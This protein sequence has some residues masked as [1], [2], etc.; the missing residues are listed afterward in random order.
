MLEVRNT[1]M[2]DLGAHLEARGKPFEALGKLVAG[3]DRSFGSL[4]SLRMTILIG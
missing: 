2:E 4:R 1:G 3:E